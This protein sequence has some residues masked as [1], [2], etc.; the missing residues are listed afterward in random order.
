MNYFKTILELQAMRNFNNNPT[1][2]KAASYETDFQDLLQSFIHSTSGDIA[3]KQPTSLSLNDLSLQN[4]SQTPNLDRL[5]SIKESAMPIKTGNIDEIIKNMA[6]KYDVDE[7]LI[8]A[9]IQQE[10]GFKTTAKS[11]AGAM[12][13]MQ[14]MPATARSLGVEDPFDAAQNVEGGT[15]YLKKM[16]SRYDGDVSLAL[17]A[18]NAGPGNVDKYGGV[19]PFKE[20]KNYVQKITS[21]YNV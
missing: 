11:H 5:A 14:L 7:K 3:I 2:M 4:N 15:K 19:P 13:L 18:Y 16:L 20:T 1:G 21:T 10:S 8:R 12:G 17:A 9:V 6:T